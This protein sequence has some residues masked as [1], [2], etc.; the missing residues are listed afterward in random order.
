MAGL[1]AKRKA[2]KWLL[3]FAKAGSFRWL[4][5]GIHQCHPDGITRGEVAESG[6]VAE[7]LVEWAHCS[8]KHDL[9]A[10]G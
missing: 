7:G 9:D 2:P 5:P 8:H 1:E 6:M 3:A 10:R 4:D